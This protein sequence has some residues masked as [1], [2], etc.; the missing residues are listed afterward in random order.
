MSEPGRES[1]VYHSDFYEEDEPIEKIMAILEGGFD[2]VTTPPDETADDLVTVNPSRWLQR[3]G[4]T[5]SRHLG[6][7]P[8]TRQ[9]STASGLRVPGC[10]MMRVTMLLA[11]AAQVAE[12]K[13]YI[14]GGGWDVW[15]G[16][17]ADGDRCEVGD[18]TGPD[19]SEAHLV[20]CAC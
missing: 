7:T 8:V 12:G 18:S 10:H 1:E 2:G 5:G 20:R 17:D 11:D 15:A 19:T 14:L 16:A 13:L 9:K 6:R 4:R 3:T